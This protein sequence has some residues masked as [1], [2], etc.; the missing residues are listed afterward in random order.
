MTYQE[1]KEYSTK[2]INKAAALI[3][4]TGQEPHRLFKDYRKGEMEIHFVFNKEGL[5]LREYDKQ[6]IRVEPITYMRYRRQLLNAV[7]RL[8]RNGEQIEETE[9]S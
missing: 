6:E 4:E 7:Q 8:K 5:P 3:C 1:S 9:K 2:D